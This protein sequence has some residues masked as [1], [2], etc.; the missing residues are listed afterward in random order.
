MRTAL[1]AALLA[2][3][4][5]AKPPYI[6][7]FSRMEE[8]TRKLN[9]VF[10][11]LREKEEFLSKPLQERI[12]IKF[13]QGAP[14]YEHLTKLTGEAVVKEIFKNWDAIE[15]DPPTEEVKRVLAMLPDV[16]K[17]QYNIVPIPKRERFNASKPL[18]AALTHD[19]FHVRQ[20]AID[21]LRAIYGESRL[22]QADLPA[23]LRS[24]RKKEWERFIKKKRS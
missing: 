24:K 20:A 17:K 13:Q 15:Q 5:L 23:P 16:L 7:D 8:L 22:Y 11:E 2:G 3:L 6:Q 9:D 18:V 12:V 14:S 19:A 1:A 4:C 10:T 21:C